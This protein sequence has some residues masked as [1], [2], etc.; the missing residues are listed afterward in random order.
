MILMKMAENNGTRYQMIKMANIGNENGMM[1]PLAKWIE[2]PKTTMP[3]KN[4][5]GN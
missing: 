2:A 4:S 1:A 5:T 3:K